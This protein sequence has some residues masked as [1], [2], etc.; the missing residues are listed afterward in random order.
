MLRLPLIAPTSKLRRDA[1]TPLAALMEVHHWEAVEAMAV[2]E[3]VKS[4][5]QMIGL[6]H[7]PSI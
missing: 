7:S 4:I 6:I 1:P 3:A 2:V 5:T